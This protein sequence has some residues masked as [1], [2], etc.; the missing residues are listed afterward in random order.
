MKNSTRLLTTTLLCCASIAVPA[1][2]TPTGSV[3]SHT[4]TVTPIVFEYPGATP[5][6][7]IRAETV[8]ENF[9]ATTAYTNHFVQMSYNQD[10]NALGSGRGESF[11]VA[12]ST[13]FTVKIK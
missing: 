5:M 11:A 7:N 13:R 1:L 6:L 9:G 2:A 3:A 4:F 8:V 10:P 12:P